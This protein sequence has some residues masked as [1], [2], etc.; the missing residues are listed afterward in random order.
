MKKVFLQI[1][2]NSQENICARV[3]SLRDYITRFFP[4]NFPKF[5][6]PLFLQNTFGRLLLYLEPCQISMIELFCGNTEA[7]VHRCSLKRCF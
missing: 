4:V 3:S 2:Q 7:V 5:V 6:R 1:S